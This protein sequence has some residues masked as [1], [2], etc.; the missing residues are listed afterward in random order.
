M[1]DYINTV[2]QAGGAV[3][4]FLFDS[5]NNNADCL[6]QINDP[7]S[8]GHAVDNYA[9]RT[10]HMAQ[11]FAMQIDTAHACSPTVTTFLQKDNNISVYPNPAGNKVTVIVKGQVLQEVVL[12]DLSGHKQKIENHSG[13]V[14][15]LPALPAGVYFLQLR[16]DKGSYMQK[17]MKD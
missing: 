1:E 16:T 2:Q 4:Q 12:V 7:S 11:L 5:T 10:L 9:L 8:I 3:P 13:D 6:Q 15:Q 17:L 14:Y